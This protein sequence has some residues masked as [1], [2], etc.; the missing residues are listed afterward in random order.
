MVNQHLNQPN[1]EDGG[2]YYVVDFYESEVYCFHSLEEAM[3][4]VTELADDSDDLDS[5]RI[6]HDGTVHKVRNRKV[7]VE[8]ELN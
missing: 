5:Y 4:E 8:L 1:N 3:Q 2:W 7:Q 6:I